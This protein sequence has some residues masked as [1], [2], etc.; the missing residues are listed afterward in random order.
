MTPPT[1]FLPTGRVIR[2]LK[3]D[4][5]YEDYNGDKVTETCYFN[6]TKSEIIELEVGYKGGLQETIQRI[7]KTQDNKQLIAEFKRLIL[8]AYGVKSDDGRRFIKSDELRE[9]FSQTAAYD[10]LFMELATNA[11]SAATFITGIVPKDFAK[12]IEKEEARQKG[13]SPV[14]VKE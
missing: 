6:L 3:R 10:S 1:T 12:E 7:I 11:D 4:I 8:L 9:E 14:L 13:L 5:S 2:V